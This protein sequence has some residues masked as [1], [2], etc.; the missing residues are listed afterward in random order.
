MRSALAHAQNEAVLLGAQVNYDALTGVHSRAFFTQTLADG[1]RHAPAYLLLFDV[2]QFKSVNDTYGHELGDAL[3]CAMA[4]EAQ[5]VCHSNDFV[6]RIGGDEF[7][8]VLRGVDMDKARARAE[9]LRTQIAARA[10]VG[11]DTAIRRTVSIGIAPLAVTDALDTALGEA[12]IA[13]YAAKNRG[14]NAAVA[15]DETLRS[16]RRKQQSEP[17]LEAVQAGLA[18]NEFTYFVQSIYDLDSNAPVGVEALIRWVQQDGTVRLPDEF[19]HMFTQQYTGAIRPPLEAANRV[20]RAMTGAQTPTYCAFN[21]STGF[22]SRSFTASPEWLD[23]LLMGI[24]PELAVFEIIESAAIDDTQVTLEMLQYLR[25]QGVRIAIDDFG[26]G[27]SNFA[28]LASLPVDIIKLDKS[29]ISDLHTSPRKKAILR[30][31]VRMADEMQ[32][33]I[34][35]EGIESQSHVDA[36]RDLGIKRGQGYFLSRPQ[37][38]EAWMSTWAKPD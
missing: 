37:T 34:V 23:N 25:S 31:V 13:L 12:D 10:S 18:A 16:T 17:S 26:T 35:A 8:V 2:D 28:R 38:L 11:E 6:A 20:A 27:F 36:V 14:R 9:T 7:C 19:L 5:Q 3:L 21:V 32:I 15:V 29:M 22:L 24:P 1:A 4:K 33:E 30:A